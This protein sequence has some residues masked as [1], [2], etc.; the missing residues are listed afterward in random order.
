M[1]KSGRMS[2]GGLFA[3]TYKA[4]WRLSRSAVTFPTKL[5]KIAISQRPSSLFTLPATGHHLQDL[6]TRSMAAPAL[7]KCTCSQRGAAK[8]PPCI[9]PI[10]HLIWG[11]WG[12]VDTEVDAETEQYS[13]RSPPVRSYRYCLSRKSLSC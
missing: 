2:E 13:V 4:Y 5:L 3:K 9:L 6:S 10:I 7:V 1:V 8:K 11:I 12:A